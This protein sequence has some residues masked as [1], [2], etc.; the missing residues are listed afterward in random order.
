MGIVAQVLQITGTHSTCLTHAAACAQP[1]ELQTDPEHSKQQA[2]SASR[3]HLQFGT[4]THL[5]SVEEAQQQDDDKQ[6]SK[7]QAQA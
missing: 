5:T 6:S 2:K 3:A 7:A 4:H 1:S